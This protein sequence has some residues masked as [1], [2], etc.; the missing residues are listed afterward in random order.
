MRKVKEKGSGES[1]REKRKRNIFERK[2]R[3]EKETR[4][5]RDLERGGGNDRGDSRDRH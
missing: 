2:L 1:K 5:R 4:K 3:T